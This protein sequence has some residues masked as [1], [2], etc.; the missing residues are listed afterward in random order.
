MS[1]PVT[2]DRLCSHLHDSLK[3][4]E[5]GKEQLIAVRASTKRSIRTNRCIMHSNTGRLAQRRILHLFV[6][7]VVCM[8]G[9]HAWCC[10]AFDPLHKPF[11]RAKHH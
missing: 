3:E 11:L 5:I 8:L 2:G 1:L 7:F 6:V 4:Q 9:V 10:A